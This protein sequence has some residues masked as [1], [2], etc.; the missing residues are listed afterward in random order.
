MNPIFNPNIPRADLIEQIVQTTVT[1]MLR[2]AMPGTEGRTRDEL[3]GIVR[4][5]HAETEAMVSSRQLRAAEAA[6]YEWRRIR[7]KL[8]G[9]SRI[10]EGGDEMA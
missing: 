5:V 6:A 7:E 8:A 10:G 2:E 1:D 4:D 9:R 3:V